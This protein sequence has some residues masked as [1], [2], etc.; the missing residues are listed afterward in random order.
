MPLAALAGV[1]AVVAWNMAERDEFW[2]LLRSSRGDAVVLLATFL[3]TVFRDL[4][5]R[6]CRGLCAGRPCCSSVRMAGATGIEAMADRPDA[7]DGAR[8]LRS[9]ARDRRGG[10]GLSPV[11]RL[12]LRHGVDFLNAVLDR[13]ADRH[14][15]LVVDFSAVPF[16]DST[17]ANAIA[18]IA[19]KAHRQ[20]AAVYISGAS[21]TI[22]RMLLI[23]G[24]RP[25]HVRFRKQLGDAV[26]AAHR[27]AKTA[28]PAASLL[29]T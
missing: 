13:I 23:H 6:H 28:E 8:A 20:G 29:P 5:R 1:M 26:K 22:R 24:V 25:P 15:A 7:A 4:T 21:R 14:K 2:T 16:V 17:A 18:G 9:Q 19:R 11:R 10:R 27:V 3:L 12:L